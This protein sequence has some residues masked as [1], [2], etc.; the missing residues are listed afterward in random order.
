MTTHMLPMPT[1]PGKVHGIVSMDPITV[2]CDGCGGVWSEGLTIITV[3]K[4]LFNPRLYGKGDDR[5]LCADCAREAGW[6][7]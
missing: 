5:R 7:R 3:G 1:V 2:Q 4:A 6:E